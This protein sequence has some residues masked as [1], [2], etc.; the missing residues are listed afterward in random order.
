MAKDMADLKKISQAERAR[1]V[2]NAPKPPSLW[3]DVVG[4]IREIVFPHG[5]NFSSFCKDPGL[6]HAMS[7][8]ED[9]FPIVHV[10]RNYKATKF[11]ND[12]MAGLTL[13]SLC[14]PQVN[15][16]KDKDC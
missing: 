2:L 14:I 9:I 10:C 15:R 7:V 1:W 6:K 8:L 12:F 11:K 4:S 5:N 3:R 13:A 16:H